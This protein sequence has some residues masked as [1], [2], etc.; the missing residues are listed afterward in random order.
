MYWCKE[1]IMGNWTKGSES[2]DRGRQMDF[3]YILEKVSVYTNRWICK[4]T[5]R[6]A[7]R[8]ISRLLA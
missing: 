8:V 7:S 6:E 2:G 5:Q 1:E 4:M 3:K